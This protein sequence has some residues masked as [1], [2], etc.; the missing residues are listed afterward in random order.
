[1]AKSPNKSAGKDSVKTGPKLINLKAADEERAA[2]Q[3]K[4]DKYANGNLSA[5]LR[6]AGLHHKPTKRLIG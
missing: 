4:A 5:W 6:Y 1:M 3:A 2:L